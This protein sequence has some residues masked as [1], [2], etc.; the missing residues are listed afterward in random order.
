[1]ITEIFK[2]L[3]DHG[4]LHNVMRNVESSKSFQLILK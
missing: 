3:R 4:N 2:I 1:M